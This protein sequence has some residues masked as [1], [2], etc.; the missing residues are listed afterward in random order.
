MR[1]IGVLMP[2]DE[3]DPEVN[4]W[5]SRFTQ[6]LSDLGWTDGRH[7]RMDVRWAADNVDR[8]RMFAKEL[9]DLQPDVILAS[10]TPATAALQ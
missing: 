7:V 9:V 4:V 5:L 6:R 10:G 1:R 2:Y 8:M 3:N